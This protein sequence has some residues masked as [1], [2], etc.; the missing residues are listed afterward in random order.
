VIA[1][2]I[3]KHKR[4]V[5]DEQAIQALEN[6]IQPMNVAA[7]AESPIYRRKAA[8]W[9][10]IALYAANGPT[11]RLFCFKVD[12]ERY[13]FVVEPRVTGDFEACCQSAWDGVRKALKPWRPRLD[14][15]GLKEN[16]AGTSLLTATTG[17]AVHIDAV[18]LVAVV[19]GV[20]SLG[21]V[22]GAVLL[23]V[24]D[25]SGR[26][27]LV[28]TAVPAVCVALGILGIATNRWRTRRLVWTR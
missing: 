8:Q 11:Y 16:L 5:T 25:A 28:L 26:V 27:G 20:V 3:V 17:F 22:G 21:L 10:N 2:L 24:S 23:W 19:S 6:A 1:E 9:T 18:S 15:A 13:Q 4:A 14:S 7:F 12:G